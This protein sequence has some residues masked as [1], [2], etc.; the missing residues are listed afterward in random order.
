MW[1]ITAALLAIG[2]ICAAQTSANQKAAV[3]P[4][5]DP[6]AKCAGCHQ[7]IYKHYKQTPMA[8]ASGPAMDGLLAGE[9]TYELSGVHYKLSLQ[10]GKAW[11]SYDRPS[12][13]PTRALNGRQE[14][15]YYIGSGKR[16]R[17]Y[18]F[19]RD[20][21]W[22]ESP[23]NW[24]AK[25]QLWDMAPSQIGV[26]EMPLTMLVSPDCLHCHASQVQESLPGSRNHYRDQPFLQSGI[27][28]ASC[29]GDATAHLAQNGKGPI[30][31]PAKLD[32]ERRDSICLQCHLEGETAVARLGYS[33]N[34]FHPGDRLFDQS[35]FFA[36]D[37]K[38]DG[39]AR[40]TSQWEALLQSACKRKS[41][42]RLTCSTCH[43]PHESPAPEQRVEYF[44]QKCLTCHGG[45]T[46]VAK[47][48]PEQQDC[49]SCHMPALT[50]ANVAHEQVTDHRILRRPGLQMASLN[51]TVQSSP[52]DL[53]TIGG[54]PA[55]DREFGLAYAQL[56]TAGNPDL[57]A[58]AIHRLLAAEKLEALGTADATLHTELGFVEQLQGDRKAADQQYRTALH[59]DPADSAAAGDL[60]LLLAQSGDFATA[61]QLWHTV[62]TN[63]PTQLTAG[64]NLVIAECKLGNNQAANSA[65]DRLLLFSPDDAKARQLKQSIAM[66]P[67]VSQESSGRPVH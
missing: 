45:A 55:G 27:T 40:S 41:G 37:K 10:D 6:D 51:A 66:K 31:N 16:G 39:S 12:S 4:A 52:N 48:H 62:F 34:S 1:Q 59:T 63:D 38:S 33:M 3:A 13:D 24:Y 64:L 49:A 50:A 15:L 14:L 53:K 26:H 36:R 7:Q 57:I 19:E 54:I 21:F 56:A 29:H 60:A 32:A 67:C 5:E 25:K 30:L 22:F 35:V 8:H 9:F 61:A 44:R 11:L 47:H 2:S 65:L 58:P 42:D 43:D 20:G 18:L 28:C 46:F 17:T 23:V